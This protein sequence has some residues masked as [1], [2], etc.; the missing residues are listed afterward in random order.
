MF[1]C[2]IQQRNG[3]IHPHNTETKD[4][5]PGLLAKSKQTN[6]NLQTHPVIILISNYVISFFRRAKNT[7]SSDRS[8][9]ESRKT[10]LPIYLL[11]K[12]DLYVDRSNVALSFH[13]KSIERPF[14]KQHFLL[15]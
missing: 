11:F 4:V 15:N 1:Q 14:Q 7:F 12:P 6:K 8:P 10:V 3:W 13:Y 2:I 9:K 5:F